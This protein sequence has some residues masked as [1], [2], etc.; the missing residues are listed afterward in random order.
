MR[1]GQVSRWTTLGLGAL[2]AAFACKKPTPQV[3]YQA[4]PVERRDI[5]VNAQAAGAI[6]PD[7]TVEV[8]SKASGEVLQINAQT[9]QLVKRGALLV[10]IDPRNARNALAQAQANLDVAKAKLANSGRQKDRADQLF[11]TQAITEE[12]H[13]SALL[14]Y[15]DAKSQVV[16][17][18]V[19]VDNAK[20][21]LEDT[22]VRAPTTGTIIEQDIERGTVIAS[23]T[24]NVSGGTT[25]LKMANLDLVQVNTLVDETDVGKI[26]PGQDAT[27]TV[28]AYA[29]RT[30][31][32]TVLKIEPQ[33]QTQQNV[34][35]FPVLV[36]IHNENGLL[37]PGMNTEV[38]IH[39][40]Q[41]DSVLAVPN[42]ALRTQRDVGSAA[43][44]LGLSAS[45][46]QRQ[47]AASAGQT[48][49]SVG[50]SPR[51]P[52]EAGD[53]TGR[54]PRD[55]TRRTVP[56]SVRRLPRDSMPARAGAAGRAPNSGAGFQGGGGFQGSQGGGQRGAGRRNRGTDASG[57]R[58][59]VFVRRN[60]APTP[61][62]IRTGLT[63]LDYSEVI[64]GLSQGDSVYILPS[65]S[66]VQS[67]QDL[68]QRV[69]QITGG[70]GVPGMRQT[71]PAGGA[72]GAGG[73]GGPA[74]GR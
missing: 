34:T 38:E 74:P 59:I 41:R 27:I 71:T 45:D 19:A 73:G 6:Q 23:A 66:L 17:A 72:G 40:G 65:A 22:D 58:Y 50:A 70:A 48:G 43:L 21:Q 25:L 44:V 32:G 12:E 7:T 57:G 39:V 3:V 54:G 37:R 20:I 52:G 53:S 67:Q 60:G 36:R 49:S 14:D 63:D 26:E 15:A 29:N 28:D 64:H 61:V 5:I 1:R 42:A 46:V 24:S 47:L 62:W 2:L 68:K 4:L 8:K 9:G 13:D 11:K 55:S 33:A 10:H 51:T 18:Q 35:V 16:N 31:E 56:D 69:N 30:F